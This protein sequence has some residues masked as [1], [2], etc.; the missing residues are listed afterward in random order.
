MTLG[1]TEAHLSFLLPLLQGVVVLWYPPIGGE[2]RPHCGWCDTVLCHRQTVSPWSWRCHIGYWCPWR[3]ED[4]PLWHIR[5]HLAC[6]WSLSLDNYLL[7][8]ITEEVPNKVLGLALNVTLVKFYQQSFVK[9]LV[10]CVWEVNVYCVCLASIIHL[11]SQIISGLNQLGLA[12]LSLTESV[13]CV[14]CNVV[15]VKVPG[16]LSSHD[17][18]QQ[19]AADGGEWYGV[20]VC[21]KVAISFFE[22]RLG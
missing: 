4:G 15:S 16:E 8:F 19:L 2:C 14:C 13:L 17:M 10:E 12:G 20:V 9:H 22:N 5:E 1:H 21:G 11:C 6:C 18:L 3:R 7:C